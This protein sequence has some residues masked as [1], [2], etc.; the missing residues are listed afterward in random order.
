MGIITLDEMLKA[1]VHFGHQVRHCNPKME[2]YIFTQSNGIDII[3]LSKTAQ[4]LAEACDFVSAAANDDKKFL[5]VGTK[6]QA[7][8][9]IEQEAKRCGAYYINQRWLGGMLTNWITIKSRVE[10]LKELEFMEQNGVFDLIPKKEAAILKRQLEKLRKSLGGIKLMSR[11]PDVVFIVDQKR[12]YNAVLEC[13]K[14]NIPIIALL[15]TNADPD[16]VD[17]PIPGND[18]AIT[19]IKLIVSKI[20]D[21]ILTTKQEK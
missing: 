16:L 9:I 3:D 21:A 13:I 19:S 20:A 2:Q 1:G 12:E 4:F 8:S 17:I 10:R 11:L 14:L 6:R 5:F 7:A 15:D 18:D